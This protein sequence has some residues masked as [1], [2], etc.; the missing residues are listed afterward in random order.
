MQEVGHLQE[1]H[2]T[3]AARGFMVVA[4]SDEEPAQVRSAMEE[5]GAG[6]P[7]GIDTRQAS[8]RAYA[9]SGSL[10]LPCFYL[11]DVDGVVVSQGLPTP[12]V[13]EEQLRRVMDPALGRELHASLSSAVADYER[14]A[15][16]R[17]WVASGKHTASDDAKLAEDAAF[18]RAKV[19]RYAA[20]QRERIEKAIAAEKHEDAMADLVIFEIRFDGM[21]A[22]AWAQQ[23]I[24]RLAEE[25][26]VHAERFAWS[27]LRKALAKEMKG[28]DSAGKLKSV[29]YAYKKLGD[30]HPATVAARIAAERSEA[31]S[32]GR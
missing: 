28:T 18:L 23:Q 31:L 7:I 27:K 3:Y 2:A 26:V 12:Q 24:D 19:E 4:I 17:A 29:L 25:E 15:C 13:I 20:W 32:R 5:H 21:E 9:G 11:V 16:G 6:Y 10:S 30:A 8:L 14:D 1:L 22:T